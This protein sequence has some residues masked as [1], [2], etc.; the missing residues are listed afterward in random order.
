[1]WRVRG[2]SILEEEER[3]MRK[4]GGGEAGEAEDG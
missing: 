4:M 3:L 1:M 2:V